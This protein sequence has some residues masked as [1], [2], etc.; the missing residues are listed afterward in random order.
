M[1]DAWPKLAPRLV[2]FRVE[3][4]L[5]TP[6]TVVLQVGAGT[7]GEGQFCHAFGQYARAGASDIPGAADNDGLGAGEVKI[8]HASG[9][10]DPV[11]GH[12]G[13]K[14]IA[15]SDRDIHFA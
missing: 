15:G 5:V 1:L 4:S 3:P 9:L 12:G 6:P 2:H 10:D 7:A 11:N 8:H 13:S 14:G